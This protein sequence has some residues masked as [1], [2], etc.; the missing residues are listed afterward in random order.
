[1][2]RVNSGT[3]NLTP[4]VTP[5]SIAALRRGEQRGAGRGALGL[6]LGLVLL[7]MAG[8][9]RR[10]GRRWLLA[11]VIAWSAAMAIGVSACGDVS[12]TPHSYTLTVT[13]QAGNLSHATTVTLTVE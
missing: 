5:S 9:L 4:Q 10:A 7:P 12:Y 6:G 3:T 1:M 11:A 13:G 2:A 8:R